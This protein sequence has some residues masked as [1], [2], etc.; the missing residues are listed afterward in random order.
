MNNKIYTSGGIVRN[1][2]KILFI[3]KRGKWDFPKG[4]IKFSKRLYINKHFDCMGLKHF[5]NRR[6]IRYNRSVDIREKQQLCL[7]Y[8]SKDVTKLT[9]QYNSLLNES[10]DIKVLI[11]WASY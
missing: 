1:G 8:N 3:F 5:I 10:R 11:P 9:K 7:H 6:T 4:K 2:Q